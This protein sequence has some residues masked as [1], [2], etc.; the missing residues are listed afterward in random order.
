MRTIEIFDFAEEGIKPVHNNGRWE[1][2]IKNWRELNDVEHIC[3][4][5]VHY[6]TDKQFALL[7]GRA[8]MIWSP[9]DP[10][11]GG[12][13]HAT[14]I[15]PGK[16]YNIP[17]GLWFNNVLSRDGRLM[18]VVADGTV[19]APDNSVLHNLSPEQAE[20]AKA[21]VRKYL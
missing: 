3:R 1:I 9:E 11:K 6:K 14:P 19:L 4:L 8:V 21:E 15:E 7:G 18:F 20:Q 17:S 16:V 12:V 2:N 13:I 5:E 10:E